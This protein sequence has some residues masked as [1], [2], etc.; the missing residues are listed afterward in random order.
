MSGRIATAVAVLVVMTPATGDACA[1]LDVVPSG[2]TL[3][4]SEPERTIAADGVLVFDAFVRDLTIAEALPSFTIELARQGMPPVT[5]T[6]E[7]IPLWSG[8][9]DDLGG[10]E[11]DAL[12][13]EEVLLVWR[14]DAALDAG[15]YTGFA[16][17]E[18]F[19]GFVE[20][21]PLA[22]TVTAGAG[23][24]IAAPAIASAAPF[25]YDAEVLERACCDLLPG[26]CGNAPYCQPTRVRVAT[27]FEI[28]A[29]LATAQVERAYLWIA[30]V[31]DGGVG[32]PV[33]AHG[34][35]VR[36]VPYAPNWSW[37]TTPAYGLLPYFE[38]E[39][40]ERCVVFGATSF[41]DGSTAMSEKFCATIPEPRDEARTPEFVPLD[42]DPLVNFGNECISPPVYEKTGVPYEPYD[43]GQPT[44]EADQSACRIGG[45]GA[46]WLALLLLT[47]RRRRSTSRPLPSRSTGSACTVTCRLQAGR[48]SC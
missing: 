16:R 23:P 28:D 5:G 12:P 1:G 13:V 20:E 7:A 18:L 15:T 32:A 10:V 38:V 26:A 29:A 19:N 4:E 48:R 35:Y 31:V 3:L 25:E 11:V 33:P 36:V 37:W 42:D 9:V 34:K 21:R 47:S 30:P 2:L 39:P 27:G 40:G 45:R 44:V 22:V 24:A 14:P 8:T 6:V 17:N 41:I 46:G 43:P